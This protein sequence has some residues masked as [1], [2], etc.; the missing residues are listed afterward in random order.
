MIKDETVLSK[1]FNRAIGGGITGASAMVVQV[2]SLMWLR[3]TMNY[4]YRY[5]GTMGNAF[6]TLY[7]D[8]GARRFYRG[9]GAAI[10]MGPLARFG[11]TASNAYV[12]SLLEDKDLP[13]TVK[14][15]AGSAAASSWRAFLMPLDAI[16]NIDCDDVHISYD[17][18]LSPCIVRTESD[19]GYI[20]VIMPIRTS[21]FD[22]VKDA[23]QA[24]EQKDEP[25][26]VESD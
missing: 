4:Q 10:A 17:S 16:K 1:A 21:D 9:Y 12:L 23:P 6:K 25:V 15:L 22:V 18:E 26:V 13:T 19:E 20:Y 5:G 8:G 24:S 11:D 7:K 2:S 14:T 3:T